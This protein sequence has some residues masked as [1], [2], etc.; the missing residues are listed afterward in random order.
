M[1]EEQLITLQRMGYFMAEA[2][3]GVLIMLLMACMSIIIG[4]VLISAFG[5]I[6]GYSWLLITYVG[7]FGF[8]PLYDKVCARMRS[9][10]LK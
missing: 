3:V 9:R 4:T 7:V 8:Y 1:T 6:G 10:R 2:I 5:D